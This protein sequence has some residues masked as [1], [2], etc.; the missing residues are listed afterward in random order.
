M[1]RRHRFAGETVE[2]RRGQ[3]TRDGTAD[4]RELRGDFED[5]IRA[6]RIGITANDVHDPFAWYARSDN[7]DEAW[8]S[9][10]LLALH[11]LDRFGAAETGGRSCASDGGIVGMVSTLVPAIDRA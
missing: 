1:H 5:W 6:G 10:M 7:R 9:H 2:I 8:D 4:P 3:G 11:L